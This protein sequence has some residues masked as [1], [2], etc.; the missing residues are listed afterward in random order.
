M[1]YQTLDSINTSEGLH[2]FYTYV[3][4]T[5]PIFTPMVLFGLFMVML[6]GSYF[7]A[8]RLRGDAN[9]SSHFAVSGFFISVIAVFMSFIP[10][11]INLP[12]MVICFGVAFI[13]FMWMMLDKN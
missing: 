4:S 11:M 6:L 7:S 10:G 1:A 9:F 13:G 2:T 5:V 8:L 3:N 12:T